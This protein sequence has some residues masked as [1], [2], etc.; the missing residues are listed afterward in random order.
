M[1]VDYFSVEKK[2]ALYADKK[3]LRSDRTE[4]AVCS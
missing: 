3:D 2:K 1:K 4:R